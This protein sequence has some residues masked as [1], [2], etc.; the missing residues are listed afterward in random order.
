MVVEWKQINQV[1]CG[2]NNSASRLEEIQHPG[3]GQQEHFAG[4]GGG[5]DEHKNPPSKSPYRWR[6]GSGIVVI[7]YKFQ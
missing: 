6:G 5:W 4:G 7:R 3:N 1:T 2:H